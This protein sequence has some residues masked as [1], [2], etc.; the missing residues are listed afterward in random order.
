MAHGDDANYW[1]AAS[2]EDADDA[3]RTPDLPA[4]D[5]FS[6]ASNERARPETLAQPA[7]KVKGASHL[8]HCANEL[9]MMSVSVAAFTLADKNA[10]EVDETAP[11]FQ[12]SLNIRLKT[13]TVPSKQR[14]ATSNGK[15][16]K[17]GD[18]QRCV[19]AEY[20]NIATT[21]SDWPLCEATALA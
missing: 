20:A 14:T 11:C 7:R 9:E 5:Y 1:E 17:V 21:R 10:T 19:L 6:G 18:F 2:L 8:A 12:N 15:A 16:K 13:K 4:V 3:N